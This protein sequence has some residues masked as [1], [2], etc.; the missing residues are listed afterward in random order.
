MSNV[1]LILTPLSAIVGAVVA[2]FA[3]RYKTRSERESAKEEVANEGAKVV[4]ESWAEYS[5]GLLE[6][7]KTLNDRVSNLERAR[8][9]TNEALAD[10]RERIANLIAKRS[11]DDS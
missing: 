10:C 11:W 7:I 4:A 9:T 1:V 2:Y 3:T 5:D 6:R 8:D